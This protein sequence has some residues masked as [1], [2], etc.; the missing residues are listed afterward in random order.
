[1]SMMPT[2]EDKLRTALR[3][4]KYWQS[5]Y[6]AERFAKAEELDQVIQLRAALATER[7]AHEETKGDLALRDYDLQTAL[8]SL[9][10]AEARVK[11]AIETLEE[12]RWLP[13]G[14]QTAWVASREGQN[15]SHVMLA[16][17]ALRA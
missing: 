7:A 13:T 2:E 4:S 16:L 12:T 3:D 6:E 9:A 14:E 8:G 1:M 15:H 11:L 17:E 5:M 10:A